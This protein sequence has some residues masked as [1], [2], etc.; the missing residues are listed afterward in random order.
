M[1]LERV[2]QKSR[3]EWNREPGGHPIAKLSKPLGISSED[4]IA[5]VFVPR[6][7]LH[8]TIYRKRI[9]RVE[10]AP[11]AGDWVALYATEGNSSPQVFGY[12]M[13]NDRAEIAVRTMRWWGQPPD[14]AFID[15]LLERAVSLRKELL[16]LDRFTDAYRVIHAES[17]GFPGLVVDRYGDTLSAEV[18]SIGMYQRSKEILRRLS[19][20]LGTKHWL[21]QPSPMFLSQE[22]YDATSFAS[23]ELPSSVV[24]TE[25][26]TRFR[27]HFES[28]H[29]T[30]FFCDQRDNRLQ[31][32]KVCQGKSVLDLCCYSGGFSVQAAKLGGASEVTGVDLDEE[33]LKLAKKNADMNQVRIKFAQSDAFAYMRDMQRLGK[34]YDIVVLDPPK[35]IRNRAEYEEGAKKHFDLNRLAMQLVKP[36][37]LLLT[38][39]CAGLLPEEEFLQIIRSA[40]KAT[41]FESD[42]RPCP[43]RTAQIL[44][45][46]GAPP[47]HPVL[48]HCPETNYLKSH[49]VRLW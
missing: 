31:L 25:S 19:A 45:S 6:A 18:F 34:L 4:P 48:A 8:P 14:D 30:G 7:M 11:K 36:G 40:A 12:G 39:S 43:P 10:G 27:V 24:I 49:W 5:S 3:M 29:K 1:S 9:D 26:G 42:G 21:I 44:W 47:D 13:F 2:N 35:L 15:R 32:A 23:A 22:G 16:Q 41:G 46:P 20:L 33:P 38:C 37:G 17:D 28:S